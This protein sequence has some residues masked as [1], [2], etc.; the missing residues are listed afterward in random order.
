MERRLRA[1]AG[2]RGWCYKGWRGREGS[3]GPEREERGRCWE[4]VRGEKGF[5]GE[6]ALG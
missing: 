3:E 2:H 5:G 6:D 4:G 1:G